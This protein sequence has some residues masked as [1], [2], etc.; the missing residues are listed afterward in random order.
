MM[1]V[2]DPFLVS[3]FIQL[4][5]LKTMLPTIFTISVLCFNILYVLKKKFVYFRT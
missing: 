2:S 5:F 1:M 4:P 3:F